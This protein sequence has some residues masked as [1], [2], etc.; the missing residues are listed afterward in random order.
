MDRIA[1]RQEGRADDTAE[2]VA[3][4]LDAYQVAT[5]PL[6]LHYADKGVLTRVPA[7]GDIDDISAEL[8]CVVASVT[9]K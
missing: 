1:G 4:R 5:D 6:V 2:T 7:M 8:G 3:A 9:E